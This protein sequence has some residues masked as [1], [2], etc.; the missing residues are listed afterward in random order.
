MKTVIEHELWMDIEDPI[1]FS[2]NINKHTRMLLE[3][4]F[5][6]TCFKG[7]YITKILNVITAEY[8]EIRAVGEK[9]TISVHMT[10]E[11]WSI[12]QDSILPNVEINHVKDAI[13]GV[14]RTDF[15]APVYVAVTRNDLAIS[16]GLFIPCVVLQSR[17][18]VS[19][20][21]INAVVRVMTRLI[22]KPVLA[23]RY[24]NTDGTNKVDDVEFKKRIEVAAAHY[25]EET[26]LT[27]DLPKS[28]SKRYKFFF[29]LYAPNTADAKNLIKDK[30]TDSKWLT[31]NCVDRAISNVGG[32]DIALEN[33]TGDEPEDELIVIC[34]NMLVRAAD[35][36]HAMRIMS[37]QFESD[38]DF[39]KNKAIWTYLSG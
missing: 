14:C 15:G 4:R 33:P 7:H 39:N 8:V 6:G 16:E 23:R 9:G 27:A 35:F 37:Q 29:D 13:K 26:A 38:E 20:S 10:A 32:G 18:S 1:N 17:L 28:Q 5:V 19:K 21:I 30:I 31:T 2:T 3:E 11:A 25:I 34:E 36:I 24:T 12:T 22:S